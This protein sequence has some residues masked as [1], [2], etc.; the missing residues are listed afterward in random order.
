MRGILVLLL[1]ATPAW[2]DDTEPPITFHKGQFGV[3]ARVGLGVRGIATY[4]NTIYCGKTDAMAE[5]GFAS[6]CTGRMPIAL[7]LEAAYGVAN[8][9]ELTLELRLG[10]ESDFGESP[11]TDGPRPFYLA[12]GARFFFSEEKHT[13]LF[14][15]PELV[16]DFA[17]Y[18]RGND[19]GLRGIEGFWI[20]LHRSYGFYFWVAE[21]LE[22]KRWLSFAFEGGIGF[23]G[24]YP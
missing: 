12:P 13:K 4:E 16:F 18:V 6:V 9:I 5:H 10:I 11:S 3:S 7:D 8:S 24:R 1:L 15:Q 19:I 22:F 14:V 23:Q 17:D 2:A 20:D 21:T